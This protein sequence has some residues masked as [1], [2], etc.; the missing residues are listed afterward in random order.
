MT[1][2]QAKECLESI[3]ILKYRDDDKNYFFDDVKG[4]L[5]IAIKSLEMWDKFSDEIEEL[6]DK[7]YCEKEGKV[8]DNLAEGFM[9]SEK[10]IKRRIKEI[11]KEIQE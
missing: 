10:A 8:Q 7:R 3:D 6:L 4:A 11:K 5:D 1:I 9:Q 2:E